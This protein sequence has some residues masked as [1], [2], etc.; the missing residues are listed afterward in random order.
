MFADVA[1]RLGLRFARRRRGD[2]A[3]AGRSG[4]AG[5][6]CRAAQRKRR[7]DNGD[8]GDGGMLS[9]TAISPLDLP[10]AAD[11]TVRVRSTIRR[12]VLRL[13][14]QRRSV[15]SSSEL[16]VIPVA[17]L[18]MQPTCRTMWYLSNEALGYS[19]CPVRR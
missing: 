6:L 13:R 17:G 16:K 12:S 1:R 18:A 10:A 8:N 14:N 15:Y 19:G 5:M 4:I 2:P 3:G 9:R 11:N 7:S